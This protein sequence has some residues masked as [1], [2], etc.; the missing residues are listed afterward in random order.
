VIPVL[1][2]FDRAIGRS[3]ELVLRRHG[4]DLEVIVNGT[5]LVSTAN[6]ASSRALVSAALPHLGGDALEVLIGGLGLGYALDE[7][8]VVERVSRVT[9]AEYE[10]VIVRW[11]RSHG[12]GRAKRAAAGE[13]AGRAALEVADVADV[14]A[15]R[16]GS[17]DLVL[18][19]TD[20]GPEWLVRGSNA[21]RGAPCG[22][23]ERSC[24]GRPNATRH[25]RLSWPVCSPASCR[26]RPS[27]W[28]RAALLSTR[29]TWR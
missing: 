6:E 26:W 16:P 21:W 3:G 11:F 5:F 18:L 23:A 7:A 13:R 8:L 1:E 24:S 19:D 22:R 20:N 17:F 4:T 2:V 10:P 14:L 29:C 15:A 27:T 25:L 28:S 12:E 9:V